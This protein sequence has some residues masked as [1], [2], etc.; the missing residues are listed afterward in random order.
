MMAHARFIKVW[1]ILYNLGR[2]KVREFERQGVIHD[3]SA[4]ARITVWAYRQTSEFKGSAGVQAE[5]FSLLP[6]GVNRALVS[7]LN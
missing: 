2:D 5:E 6:A 1:T 4:S 3:L 7:L